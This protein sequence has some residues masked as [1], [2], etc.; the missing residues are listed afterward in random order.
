MSKI[1]VNF[2]PFFTIQTSLH[3]WFKILV[4]VAPFKKA[5]V[6]IDLSLRVQFGNQIVMIL[7]VLSNR[8]KWH[9]RSHLVK[10]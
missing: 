9:L 6:S 1:L 4:K 7:N 3:E 2:E 10:L 5:L 8:V